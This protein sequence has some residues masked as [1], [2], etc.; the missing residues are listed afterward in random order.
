[1]TQLQALQAAAREKLSSQDLQIKNLEASV[2]YWTAAYSQKSRD[3]DLNNLIWHRTA[4]AIANDY[5]VELSR[6]AHY[7]RRC[8]ELR[9][10]A[11]ADSVQL[12]KANS[13]IDNYSKYA[14]LVCIAFWLA[15]LW[16]G[17]WV[18]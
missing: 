8:D 6:A 7:K 1:M 5:L 12:Q 15:G 2:R 13:K 10:G 17:I 14:P 18:K 9:K 4:E 16:L 11:W 3:N